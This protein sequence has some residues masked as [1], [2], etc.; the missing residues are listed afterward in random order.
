[1]SSRAVSSFDY[2]GNATTDMLAGMGASLSQLPSVQTE[3]YFKMRD[4]S[5]AILTHH[6]QV[7]AYSLAHPACKRKH[8]ELLHLNKPTVSRATI[9]TKLKLAEHTIAYIGTKLHCARCFALF[10]VKQTSGFLSDN[11]IC[12]VGVRTPS[13]HGDVKLTLDVSM[14]PAVC[15]KV[16]CRPHNAHHIILRCMMVFCSVCGDW[17][18]MCLS[19]F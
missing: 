7:L 4:K 10:V 12:E 5:I 2:A 13:L 6:I 8:N 19:G 1:V 15:D 3:Q 16:T 17:G 18:S 14:Q 9:L 11:P